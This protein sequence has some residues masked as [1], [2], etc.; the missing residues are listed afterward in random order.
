LLTFFA[1]V[2]VGLLL[3]CAI[4]VVTMAALAASSRNQDS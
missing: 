2:I 4:G 3:G 1:G